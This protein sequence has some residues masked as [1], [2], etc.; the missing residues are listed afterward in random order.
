MKTHFLMYTLI[1]LLSGTLAGHT[2]GPGWTYIPID[3]AKQKWGDWN[4]PNWLRYFGLDF[5]DVNRDGAVDIVSGRYVY[6]NPG[7]L[8]ETPWPRIDLGANVDAIF[9]LDADGDPF[10]DVIA[11]ALPNIYWFEAVD[12]EGTKFSKTIISTIPKT[13][14]VNSQGF[15]KAQIVPGG[16]LEL[17][18]A[19]DGNVYCITIPDNPG[20]ADKWPTYMIAKNTS[21][22]GIGV[23]DVDNDGDLDIAC[24]RRPEGE[25]E[26]LI[27]V[28][29]ENPGSV[30]TAWKD[31]IVGRTDKPID[32]VELGDLNGDGKLEIVMSE[33]RYPGKEPDGKLLWFSQKE[34][35]NQPWSKHR[36]VTQYSMNNLDLADIDTDGDID[37]ITNEHK[38]PRLETQL[39]LNDGE[40]NFSK[41]VLDTGKE[42][43]L[44]AQFYDL[45]GDGDLDV[46]GCAWDN[47]QWMHVWR[48]DQLK[49]T[50]TDYEEK[51]HFVVHTQA[52]TYYYD[53]EG[54]GFSR[55]IDS[56]GA[57][58]V[59]FKREPW[60]TYPDSAA[61]AFRGLPNSVWQ[62]DDDGAGHPGHEKC[63]S[64]IEDNQIVTESLSGKW[65][66]SW[67]FFDD[68]A[69][70]DITKT[71][72]DR[73]YWFLYEGTPGGVF[74]PSG[75]Y[76]GA[77][78]GDPSK[79]TPDFSGGTIVEGKFQWM[80]AG[81]NQ[82]NRVFYMA[83]VKNDNLED[84][85]SYLGNSDKGL[86]SKDGMAV[87]G[88]GRTKNTKPL[89]SGPQTF[90]IG[91]YPNQIT[92][93]SQHKKLA[94]FLHERMAKT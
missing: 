49:V 58:W 82:S 55:M 61:S 76:F 14:H 38:G 52:A 73:T 13:S 67:Q 20:A 18:I 57:D 84:V 34:D 45:D 92:T 3:D 21:D 2:A 31:H 27:L 44:G 53:I 94:A 63:K 59:S 5:G 8:M 64:W 39:W 7:G 23:G 50:K 51:P 19:S 83:Q 10:A 41:Q 33:E 77:D 88:F 26:P 17:V 42:N 93:K 65:K 90:V 32:R 75:S 56:D 78:T 72:M 22:E 35:V 24:G 89:L 28:W 81:H 4:E 85:I 79:E 47:Y 15:E 60:G 70:L 54:G 37:I 40:A 16:P 36:V 74:D 71:D 62:G 12:R 43:H 11:Q 30:N 80:Y 29:F 1:V 46:A 86:K 66:W 91:F 6:H 48:N 68:H 9:T 69:V 87:F 25:G